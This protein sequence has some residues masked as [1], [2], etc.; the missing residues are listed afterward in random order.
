MDTIAQC[1]SNSDPRGLDDSLYS[2]LQDTSAEEQRWLIRIILKDVRIFI[3][4][5]RILK[6]YHP[7][8]VD[9]YNINNSLSKVCATLKDPSLLL[10]E[11]E[12]EIFSPFRPMLSQRMDV[13]AF[14]K[15]V[16]D[17]RLFYIETKFDGERFQL[18]MQ[19]GEFR[20]FSRNGYDYTPTYGNNFRTGLYT[21]LLKDVLS[22]NVTK[23][24][25]DGEMMG[26]N[27]KTKKLGSKGMAFDVKKL[28]LNSVHQ[29]CFCV[30]DILVLNNKIL[31]NKPLKERLQ[32][33]DAILKP[34]EG[35]IVKS[36]YCRARTKYE[37]VKALNDSMDNEEEGIVF[38]D[39]QSVYKSNDRNAGW[40]KMKLEYFEGVMSDLDVVIIGGYYGEKRNWS[41]IDSFLLAVAVPPISG[42]NPKTFHSF[43]RISTG[44]SVEERKVI[45]GKLREYWRKIDEG[46]PV[47]SGVMW[48]KYLLLLSKLNTFI[49]L[50]YALKFL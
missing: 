11:L 39:T 8:A 45:N 29:P 48:S 49:L 28:T 46:D 21:P 42:G 1:H 15:T 47:G 20:Y 31:T 12:I 44:L 13:K 40:Y 2:L 43:A 23:I 4:Q 37:I 41:D 9:L 27:K 33:L 6:T 24:I 36:K 26:W 16:N 25:L 10:H 50:F 38:K 32:L 17:D 19:N 5:D 18:H 14:K 30:F 7:D 3:G 22:K 34:I 35:T